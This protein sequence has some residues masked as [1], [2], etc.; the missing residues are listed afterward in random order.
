MKNK[1]KPKT[2]LFNAKYRSINKFQYFDIIDSTN[3]NK[4]VVFLTFSFSIYFIQT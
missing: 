4:C 2:T 1:K 3:S